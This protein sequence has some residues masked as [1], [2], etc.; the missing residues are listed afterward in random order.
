MYE[1]EEAC[2]TC[3]DHPTT[4]RIILP[5]VLI[6]SLKFPRFEERNV[7]K[8]YEHGFLILFILGSSVRNR[9]ESAKRQ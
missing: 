6:L 8:Q 7:Q 2:K 9:K 1:G 4:K 5:V 3:K